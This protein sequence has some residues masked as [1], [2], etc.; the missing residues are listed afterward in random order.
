MSEGAPYNFSNE[1]RKLSDG[2]VLCE[3]VVVDPIG[4]IFCIF[5]DLW[6]F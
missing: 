3:A 5:D 4:T 2:H 1:A 6:I